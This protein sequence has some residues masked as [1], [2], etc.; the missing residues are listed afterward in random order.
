MSN[1]DI[2][3]PQNELILETRKGVHI[4]IKKDVYVA[5][6]R[7]LVERNLSLQEVVSEMLAEIVDNS[8]A[9][10]SGVIDRISLKKLKKV[11]DEPKIY[12]GPVKKIS[13]DDIDEQTLYDLI[14]DYEK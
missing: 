1:F 4:N 7:L 10:I 14:N 2:Y 5:I 12:G 3:R 11:M 8:N 13:I 9:P 6:R